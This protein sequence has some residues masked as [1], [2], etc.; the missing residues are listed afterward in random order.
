MVFVKVGF[1]MGGG[2]N[3]TGI[4]DYMRQLDQAA[5]PFSLKSVNNVGATEEAANHADAS[6]IDHAI[7]LRFTNPGG[8]QNEA[9]NYHLSPKESALDWYTKTKKSIDGAPEFEA[10]KDVV[11]IEVM[12]ELRTKI[13][14]DDPMYNNMH[15]CNWLGFFALHLGEFLNDAG[16]KMVAFGMNSG[17]P[18]REDWRRE[19][20][21]KYLTACAEKPNDL[22]VGLHEY[23]GK[24]QPPDKIYNFIWG[25]FEWLFDECDRLDISRPTTFITEWGWAYNDMPGETTAMSDWKWY[26]K[27][28]AKYPNLKGAFAW[29]LEGSSDLPDKLQRLIEPVTEYAKTARFPDP[30]DPPP[31]LPP[32]PEPG[33]NDC[34]PRI[35]YSRQYWVVE[36]TLPLSQRQE[37]YGMAAV[38]NITAG[39]SHDDAG[40]G[41]HGLDSNTAVLW[42]IKESR[43]EE[44]NAWYH[45]HYTG[46]VVKYRELTITPDPDPV[47]VPGSYDGPPI[48]GDF[49]RGVDQ[50]ASDWDWPNA[51][52]VFDNTGLIP[53]FHTQGTNP[54]WFNQYKNN[55]FNAVRILLDPNFNGDVVAEV[56]A[57]I[58]RFYELGARDFIV[59]NEPN[60]E[61]INKRW[62][63]ATEF[64]IQYRE[65]TRILTGMFPSARWWYPGMS[66]GGTDSTPPE[67]RPQHAWID[68]VRDLGGFDYTYGMCMHAYT[69]VVSN[70]DT[71]ISILVNEVKT[72][73]QLHTLSMPLLVGE[74]SVNRPATAAYKA[75]IYQGLWSAIKDLEGLQAAY[76]FTSSWEGNPDANQEGWKKHG[77]D[78]AWVAL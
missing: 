12:N 1:H 32:P 30:D 53:K 46:T 50:P 26:S 59:L 62:D 45:K 20:M 3:P 40:F 38:K 10:I 19:G 61:G 35:Q 33:L 34:Q 69:G 76:S 18:E 58:G 8:S 25:R 42:Q 77:I 13:D 66:P 47:P 43:R 44:L 36:H 64:A 11:W 2:G 29:T 5:I 68:T 65:I 71:A 17:T 51:K 27:L 55:G 16:Y 67:E 70:Q 60:I 14:P 22:A 73:Q 49:V 23:N 74:F 41:S 57:D 4:G 6:G 39:N 54:E 48:E 28:M 56:S 24:F 78:V 7:I 37:I 72:F 75:T 63:S 31:I 52:S 21:V 15:P 9:P